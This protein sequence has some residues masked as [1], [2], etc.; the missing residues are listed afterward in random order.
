MTVKTLF[1]HSR[2]VF[3]QVT[4]LVLA[5]F[6]CII[7]LCSILDVFSRTSSTFLHVNRNGFMHTHM[8]TIGSNPWLPLLS[9][10]ILT[11]YLNKNTKIFLL[12]LF[13]FTV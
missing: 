1:V 3:L 5:E 10:Y 6:Y 9:S 4:I 11:A 8:P 12:K 2:P 13:I 7:I